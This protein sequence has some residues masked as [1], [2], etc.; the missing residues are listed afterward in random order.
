MMR[1]TASSA[2]KSHEKPETKTSP[3][4][5]PAPAKATTTRRVSDR[6]TAQ[7]RAKPAALRPQSEKSQASTKETPTSQKEE[8]KL[9]PKV[10]ESEKENVKSVSPKAEDPTVEAQDTIVEQP[11]LETPVAEPTKETQPLES[12]ETEVTAEAAPEPAVETIAESIEASTTNDGGKAPVEAPIE[13]SKKGVPEAPFQPADALD[14]TIDA[15]V[16]SKDTEASVE[17]LAKPEVTATEEVPAEAESKA[18]DVEETSQAHVEP[19]IEDVA[20]STAR[21]AADCEPNTTDPESAKPEVEISE[22]LEPIEPPVQAK[23]VAPELTDSIVLEPSVPEPSSKPTDEV[24]IKESAAIVEP[25]SAEEPA[26]QPKPDTV[27]ID[28]AN[29]LS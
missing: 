24:P 15:P 13:E 18:T 8:A 11:E 26:P 10:Q 14:T 1:P 16:E 27:D 17:T 19:D 2:S 20:K 21:S 29:Q 6:G 4:S 22:V 3:K 28:F 9:A 12:K 7:A 23:D 5:N 25:T